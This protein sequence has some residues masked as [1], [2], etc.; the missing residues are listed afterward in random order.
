[1]TAIIFLILRVLISICLYAFLLVVF[2]NLWNDTRQQGIRISNRK[3][4]SISLNIRVADRSI[5]Q[6][7]FDSEVVS[8]GRDPS[9]D[10]HLDDENVSNDHARL[11]YHHSQ[12]WLEDLGSTNGTFIN[13]HPVSI[14]V[15][16]ISGDEITCGNHTI[17]IEIGSDITENPQKGIPGN[18]V[19]NE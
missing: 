13:E 10:C 12:W 9:N 3:I 1:M 15:V 7:N 4:P 6:L 17:V 8:I 18:G 5:R 16:I 19:Q 2:I 11:K 14:P